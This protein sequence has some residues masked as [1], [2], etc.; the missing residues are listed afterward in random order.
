MP[1]STLPRGEGTKMKKELNPLVIW[2]ILGVIVVSVAGLF[3]WGSTPQRTVTG[4]EKYMNMPKDKRPPIHL[5][6]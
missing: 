6:P 5:E 1:V 3:W 2:I 4:M